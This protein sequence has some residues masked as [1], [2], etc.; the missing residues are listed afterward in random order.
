[1]LKKRYC[2]LLVKHTTHHDVPMVLYRKNGKFLVDYQ[3]R[4]THLMNW[5]QVWYWF[6]L[7][8]LWG[9]CVGSESKQKFFKY[10]YTSGEIIVKKAF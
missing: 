2:L 4:K 8:H 5:L 6:W 1:M 9:A 3:L 10:R 7:M